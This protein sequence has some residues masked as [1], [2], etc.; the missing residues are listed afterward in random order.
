MLFALGEFSNSSSVKKN[1]LKLIKSGKKNLKFMQGFP[2]GAKCFH[3]RMVYT[4]KTMKEFKGETE[5]LW[6]NFCSIHRNTNSF[7]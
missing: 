5:Y 2:E 1:I 3:T 6:F 7:L 4:A